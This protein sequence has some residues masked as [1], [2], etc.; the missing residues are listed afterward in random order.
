MKNKYFSTVDEFKMTQPAHKL[1]AHALK[2]LRPSRGSRFAVCIS[3][4][5]GFS[6]ALWVGLSNETID[7][8][9]D[10][11]SRFLAVQ[12]AIFGCV[13]AVYSI[14]LAFLSDSY[15]KRLSNISSN[16]GSSMLKDSTT[17]YE[18][19]LFLYFINIGISGL[20]ILALTCLSLDFRLSDN[21]R[22]D[23]VLATVSLLVY[24]SFC[25]RTFYELKSTIYNTIVLFRAS[26][27]YKFLDFGLEED[28]AS[29]GDNQDGDN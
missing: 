3:F 16:E 6:F 23:T 28:K 21:L 5:L 24:F 27:A 25:F 9:L 18:S 19:V 26:I 7:L 1:I 17:Y 13:F 14:L 29:E 4:I 20:I 15:M 12:L 22:L 8:T 11:A 10:I 2:E